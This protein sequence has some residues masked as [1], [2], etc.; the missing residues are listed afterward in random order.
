MEIALATLL[1]LAS[2]FISALSTGGGLV[3]LPGLL[4]LGLSPISA[5]A[6]SR[7]GVVSAAISSSY[8]YYKGKAISW[9]FMPYFLVMAVAA[10][11]IGPHIVLHLNQKLVEKGIGVLLLALL[12]L[13][14]LQKDI[15]VK[16]IQYTRKRR[17]IGAGLILL[18][19]FYTTMFGP[20]AGVLFT[21]VLV[22]MFGMKVVEANATCSV[23][24]LVASA[25]AL[26]SYIEIG[27]VAFRLGIPL[28]AGSLVGGYLGARTALS[29]GSAWVKW[30]LAVVIL[31]SSA[32]L[33]LQ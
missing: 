5:I 3:S 30:L 16:E 2:G 19:L 28:A 9:Q 11:I 23:I 24:A 8:R 15:G 25:I 27:S 33:L 22:Y 14:F 6:T 18:V 1:G 31:A 12:P 13:L 21:Y 17:T 7:F 20:G 26:V 4:F 29:K 10:G 32:K